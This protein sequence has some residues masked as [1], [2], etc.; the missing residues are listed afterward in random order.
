MGVTGPAIGQILQDTYRLERLIGMG[1]MGA[2]YEASHQ[3]LSR[4]F[5]VKMLNPDVAENAEALERFRREA[6]ITSGLG[7]PNILD[8]IDFNHTPDGAPYII[9]E[10]LDGEDLATR[11][12]RLGRL[13]LHQVASIFKQAASAL[14]A[15][16][17]NGIVHRDLKPQNIFLCN[18]QGRDDFVKV[19]DFGVSKI[20]GSQ[21]PL[22]RTHALLGT[23]FYMAPEQAEERAAE[24][25]FR[26]D[27]YAMATIVYELLAGRPPFTGDSIPALLYRIV[28]QEPAPLQTLQPDVP[29]P[30]DAVIQQ[31]L[32]KRPG[33]R[34]G[35]MDEFWRE[36]AAAI[37]YDQSRYQQVRATADSPGSR[38]GLVGR[39][40]GNYV[41]TDVLG[42]GGMGAVYL[43]E[44][45]EIGRQVAIKVLASHLIQNQTAAERFVSEAK[46]VT[47]IDHP[48][49]I[50]IYDFGRLEDGRLYYVM[51]KLKGR[52]LL[53]VMREK[54]KMAAAEVLPYLEQICAA[55]QAAH[56]KGIVHRDL[57]PENI[58]VLDRQPLALKILDFGIA[59][60][61]ETT[62]G[63]ASLTATG[64]V[65][66]TP[67]V[68]APEQAAGKP[69]MICPRTDLYSL[70]VIVYWMLAGRPP[71]MDDTIALLLGK[72]ILDPPPPLRDLEPSV[73][74]AVARLVEQCLEKEPSRRPATAMT[75][76]RAYAA[77]LIEDTEPDLLNPVDGASTDLIARA[78][79]QERAPVSVPV[80]QTTLG[81]SVG[82]VTL[83]ISGQLGRRSRSRWIALAAGGLAVLGLTAF[84]VLQGSGTPTS[85]AEQ[86]SA[87]APDMK[88]AAAKT[89]EAP[90]TPTPR[91]HTITVSADGKATC[92]LRVGS[93]DP[94]IRPVPCRFEAR[95]GQQIQLEV[96]RQGFRPYSTRWGLSQ[97]R[98]FELR[99]L[100]Q[101]RRIVLASEARPEPATKKA[102][103]RPAPPK[104]ARPTP[105]VKPAEKKAQPT[106]ATKPET[107]VK[108]AAPRVEP[109]DWQDPFDKTKK[110][111]KPPAPKQGKKAV[112]PSE[113]GEGTIPLPDRED[114]KKK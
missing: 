12:K 77:A 74:P 59:K 11:K 103:E 16:H 95:A 83:G 47:R 87:S 107:K 81:A 110:A 109:P 34:F 113:V 82:E 69:D 112:V 63:G 15:V 41:V 14:Q 86:A 51:E 84:V 52:E 31:A 85:P 10:L 27:M 24:V 6:E 26:T 96:I 4:G 91:L 94:Q 71:F 68:I 30:V 75:I 5:A 60:L 99:L 78:P 1:G 58:F 40:V 45:P 22:T 9:M 62:Q 67:L 21:S 72:H 73:P 93:D 90:P 43:A 35:S 70:G 29:L 105:P 18:S 92:R 111:A 46:A 8:V 97:D 80:G 13:G 25:D 55:L 106:P 65:M 64:M 54:E 104:V 3:R 50:D 102:T 66:G 17:D 89:I 20:L 44:H 79:G 42:E 101:A 57:K 32:S 98:D 28:Q 39:Q 7:H 33:D 36:F 37:N 76:A 100:K 53:A 48:N 19:V 88:A 114:P 61:L 23:P 108:A 49:I 56:D 2:V 38:T